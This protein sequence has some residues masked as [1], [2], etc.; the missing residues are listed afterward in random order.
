MSRVDGRPSSDGARQNLVAGSTLTT[1]KLTAR[2]IDASGVNAGEVVADVGAFNTLTVENFI[3]TAPHS[4]VTLSLNAAT[5]TDQGFSAGLKYSCTGS[6]QIGP[7]TSDETKADTV[8]WT[9]Y[10]PKTNTTRR[11]RVSLGAVLDGAGSHKNVEVRVNGTLVGTL[12]EPAN[13]VTP[14]E[15]IYET[16]AFDWTV[17][18]AMTVVVAMPL[19]PFDGSVVNLAADVSVL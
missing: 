3:L 9:T 19:T 4:T 18:A 15:Y 5:V 11:I 6:P 14:S 10:V 16:P 2:E 1:L 17:G 13:R 12:S 8:T 7:L